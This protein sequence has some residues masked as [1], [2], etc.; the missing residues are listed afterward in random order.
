MTQTWFTADQH[1]SHK[2]IIKYSNRPFDS[3]EEMN[4][5]MIERWNKKVSSSDTVYH[6]GD[7]TLMGRQ[8]ALQYLDQLN[9][10]VLFIPGGHDHWYNRQ[11]KDDGL[12]L[13]KLHHIKVLYG[14]EKIT[15]VLCHYPLLTWEKSQHGSIHLHGHSHG[16]IGV[17]GRSGISHDFP[18]KG[19]RIDVGV[20][21]WGFYPVSLDQ[22]L[23]MGVK[24]R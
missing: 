6:L 3:V 21:N 24:A 12:I 19:I 9:G 5:V 18:G 2:K 11:D 13:D 16:M 1:F 15:I 10:H 23:N 20:D 7:F 22:V 14:D 17:T 4:Q 8:K